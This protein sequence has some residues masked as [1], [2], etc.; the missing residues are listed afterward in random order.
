MGVARETPVGSTLHPF[1]V[2]SSFGF[3]VRRLGLASYGR[4]AIIPDDVLL[5]V[6]RGVNFINWQGLP[7]GA[8]DGDAFP[9]AISSVGA[10]RQR[11]V[12]CVQFG[13]RTGADAAT[14]LRSVLAVLGTDYTSTC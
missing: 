6:D 4:T 7:E 9:T 2:T 11:I 10:G 1:L 5:A 8:S 13:A 3:P 12:I 14:E